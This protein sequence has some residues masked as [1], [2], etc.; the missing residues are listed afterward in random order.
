MK[1]GD[2][3]KFK[4]ENKVKYGVILYDYK[5]IFHIRGFK[6]KKYY[7]IEKSKIS[8]IGGLERWNKKIY[9]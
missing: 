6:P 2:L 7:L 4:I 5:T 9:I 1:P 8:K 3:V